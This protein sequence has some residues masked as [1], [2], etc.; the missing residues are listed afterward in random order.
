[1]KMDTYLLKC[2]D[3]GVNAGVEGV[4]DGLVGGVFSLAFLL[5]R[6]RFVQLVLNF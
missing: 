5:Q 1:M 3:D 2:T 6:N 4:V